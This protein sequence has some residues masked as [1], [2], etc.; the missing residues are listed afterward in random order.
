VSDVFQQDLVVIA[1][2]DPFPGSTV[3]DRRGRSSHGYRAVHVVVT[4]NDRAVEIQ[5]RTE[6]QQKW[7]ELSEKCADV[8][9]PA[10]KYGGGDARFQGLLLRLSSRIAEI[11][12]LESDLESFWHPDPDERNRIEVALAG[13][14]AQVN[15]DL[16]ALV[17]QL[18]V[19]KREAN[20][21]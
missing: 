16:E 12:E 8:I 18:D 13:F 20:N 17:R 4:V 9:D 21:Q 7:A 3:I 10:I 19:L 14:K 11:E 1:L 6:A 5:V 15:A 2:T